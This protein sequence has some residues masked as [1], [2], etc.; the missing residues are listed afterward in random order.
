RERDVG[1]LRWKRRDGLLGGT[2]PAAARPATTPGPPALRAPAGQRRELLL[3]RRRRHRRV[4]ARAGT[5]GAVPDAALS[6]AT[7]LE[8]GFRRTVLPRP[9]AHPHG[10]GLPADRRTGARR[11]R[12]DA[13]WRPAE[14]G[15]RRELACLP[16]GRW[17]ILARRRPADPH[18]PRCAVRRCSD[19]GHG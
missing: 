8:H 9:H 19:G 10:D 13:F 2:T 4:S 11:S 7:H 5:H 14:A 15:G 1:L 6:R 17:R 16:A 12:A 3:L 18:R